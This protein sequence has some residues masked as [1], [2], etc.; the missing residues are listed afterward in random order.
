MSE[1][2]PGYQ[3]VGTTSN[4]TVST[5]HARPCTGGIVLLHPFRVTRED[6]FDGWSGRC[7]DLKYFTPSG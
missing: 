3:R 5:R 4:L 6:Y 2:N 7:P 1:V